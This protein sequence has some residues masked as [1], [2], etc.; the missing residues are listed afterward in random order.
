M[1]SGVDADGFTALT[2]AVESGNVGDVKSLIG[3]GSD[4]NT[5][6][7]K[8]T[9][10]FCAAKNGYL[11]ILKLLLKADANVNAGASDHSMPLIEAARGKHADCVDELIQAGAIVNVRDEKKVT[12]LIA[13]IGNIPCMD[14]LVKAG[15]QLNPKVD[16]VTRNPLLE[17]IDKNDIESVKF[18]MEKGAKVPPAKQCE[19]YN[20][21]SFDTN[22]ETTP[23]WSTITSNNM[24]MFKALVEGG[25]DLE[26]G[27]RATAYYAH[28]R[29]LKLMIEEGANVNCV[30]EHGN[31]VLMRAAFEFDKEKETVETR[32]SCVKLVLQAGARV[33]KTNRQDRNALDRCLCNQPMR[34]TEDI[35]RLLFAAGEKIRDAKPKSDILKKL[36][37]KEDDIMSLKAICRKSIRRHLLDLDP[38]LN[39][40]QR[41]P[42]F[43]ATH[44]VKE[45][46]LFRCT[47]DE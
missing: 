25:A 22:V 1:A 23:L 46:M 20:L 3:E 47:L 21:G 10:L 11:N 30:D 27:I 8:G 29:G 18:L 26:D 36:K 4:V 16:G 38:H 32:L 19:L 12:P 5:S 37:A 34:F 28:Y 24:D 7:G 31:T 14:I 41:I 40:F 33:N 42:K 9:P 6:E 43:E 45:Y 39:L 15:V 13:A 2:R 44:V 35:A 17:A